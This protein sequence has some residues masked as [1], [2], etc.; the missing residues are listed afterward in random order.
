[1]VAP[2]PSKPSRSGTTRRSA[3]GLILGAPLIAG[4]AGSPFG[5][6][7]QPAGPGRSS[8]RRWA[9]VRSRSACCCRCRRP[10]MPASPRSRCATPPSWRWRNFRTQHP[11]SDQGRRRHCAGRPA[12]RAAG[13]RRR[14]GNHS[15][16]AV[17]AVGARR[18]AGRAHARHS[19]IAFSTDSSVAGRGVYLLS[20]LPES[21][22]NRIVDYAAGTGKRSF[23]AISARERLRQCGRGR[24][25]AGGGAQGRPHRCVREIRRGSRA[26]AVRRAIAQALASADSL[27]LADD[28]DAL[29]RSRIADLGGRQSQARAIARHRLWDNPRVFANANLQGGLYAAPDPSGFPQLR[30]RAI[31]PNT[32]VIRCAPRRWPM[33]RGA[34]RGAGAHAGRS[35]LLA[36]G[37]DQSVRLRRHRRVVSFPQRRH[38]RARPRGD[39]RRADRRRDC[40]GF[41]EE[42]RGVIF[43]GRVPE[44]SEGG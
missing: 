29:P 7:E 42:L 4:C 17:R 23:A 32:A 2:F 1:M 26:D 38:Q 11:A 35:A 34:G 13:R 12:R 39:A 27:L 6:G 44:Q 36:G 9:V 41:A 25:Q 15:R 31:A 24:L 28:G 40:R 22:V 3:V 37:S 14:R 21:D 10:A 43:V 20:F 30:R 18:G 5:G 33:T 16:A 19:V 8:P